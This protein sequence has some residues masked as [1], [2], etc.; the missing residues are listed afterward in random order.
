M[1]DRDHTLPLARQAKAVGISRGSI[2]YRP[3]PVGEAGL[4]L[5]RRIDELHLEYPFA[6]SRMMRGLLRQ[7]G[8]S[9]GRRHIATLMRRMGI[10]ALYRK[11]NT[12]RRRPGHTVYPY[13]L[14]GLEVSR[15]NQVWAMDITYIPMARGF[16]YL[17]AVMD[18]HSRKVLAWRVSVTM[19]TD[20]CVE[21][22]GE[23]LG[24][25]GAP[26]IF[27][28]DQGSQFTSDAFTGLLKANGIQISMDGKGSWKDNV[29]VERLWK[30]VKY[31]EVYLRA[32]ESV[33][34]ARTGLGRYF[35]FYNAGRPHSSLGGMTPDQFFDTA[36][37]ESSR[38]PGSGVRGR[39]SGE[40][41]T[42]A[43]SLAGKQ[44]AREKE[45]TVVKERMDLLELLHKGGM[46]GDVDFLREALRVLVEGIMD[47]EVS[48]RI[49]AE[50]GERSP[51]R[52]TQ[53]N[54]YRS[55]AWDTRVGT[56]ELHIPKLREGSYFPSLLEPRR[57]SERALLAVI[58]QAYVEGVSTRRVDD[59]VKALGCEG[60]SKSQ[61]SRICQ[62]LDV[63]VD[64]FLGRPLDGGPYPYLWLDALTQKV[65]EDGRIVNV[66][67][68]VATAVNGEGKREIIGMDVGT[69]E[70]GA[71]WLAFLRS[72][73]ARGLS[74]VELVVSDA[75]QGL[76]GAIAAVFGGAS[77][78]R[79]RTHFM[80]NLLTRVPRRAQPWVAT[81]V[82]TIYQQPSPDEV[83]AQLD[84]VTSQLHDRFPEVAS[85]LDEA[86][87]DVLAFSSFPLAHWKKLWSNNPQ[88]RLNKEIRRR[89]DVVGIF[90]NR[91]AV[92]RL[93][94]AVLAEQH[95]EWVVG[96]RYL[97]PAILTFNEALPEADLA[98]ATAA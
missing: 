87:P 46:D 90:P 33:P 96:R 69:S 38:V 21:A 34:E 94:G 19:D 18:W 71:F 40:R 73:S 24:R 76:R 80:T 31:L 12:S 84:R 6:G 53:R 77:W 16:V 28:T 32:Y 8:L 25:H 35:E 41:E 75:H 70:D 97:T 26:E 62:E 50:Y 22:L 36:P 98:E 59:L 54:G 42:T 23:S 72:L 60:I 63:V 67:V 2:Y 95:D 92:R 74:G 48:S 55:R 82:R 9:S 89:T 79:C 17:A 93:V 37:A 44:Q 4:G 1:I 47:A 83:H 27:N 5:M 7:E 86:G 11:P 49:G 88:E 52:V 3:R 61:V 58:Q 15:P 51:E 43:S 57:R 78:Q 91:P 39:G 81:M 64:G 56:M 29:F 85:L 66:S 20:F 30:S 10:D 68:V 65:R 14:R 13:L 45:E